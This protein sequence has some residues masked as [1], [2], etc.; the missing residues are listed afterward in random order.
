MEGKSTHAAAAAAAPTAKQWNKRAFGTDVTNTDLKKSKLVPL[1][2]GKPRK[3]VKTRSEDLKECNLTAQMQL[4]GS[5]VH[6]FG[7]FCPT[8]VAKGEHEPNG[9]DE[10]KALLDWEAMAA[11]FH[12]Q[13]HNQGKKQ[14]VVL[15]WPAQI[16]CAII[17]CLLFDCTSL[18]SSGASRRCAL[19]RMQ[20]LWYVECLECFTAWFP[21]DSTCFLPRYVSNQKS[22]AILQS[23]YFHLPPF[24]LFL[25]N[26]P[27][28]IYRC[29][30]Y[31]SDLSSVKP[32]HLRSQ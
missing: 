25:M 28:E 21:P 24:F 27:P 20:N 30:F 26:V 12:P 5:K 2:E 7:P 23:L 14:P 31:D 19:V 18:T 29:I 6:A 1:V 17:F 10:E 3:V 11:S 9:A 22:R 16:H 32:C 13:Y 8:G 4:Q 15:H